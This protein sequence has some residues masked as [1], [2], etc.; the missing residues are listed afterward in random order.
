MPCRQCIGLTLATFGVNPYNSVVAIKNE[1][2]KKMELLI[3]TLAVS[4]VA[5]LGQLSDTVST[6]PKTTG[7]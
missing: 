2:E 5:L 6:A 3:I 4:A 1:R 7:V